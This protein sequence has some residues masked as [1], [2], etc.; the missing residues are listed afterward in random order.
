MKKIIY[1]I[2]S[3]ILLLNIGDIYNFNNSKAIDKK[4]YSPSILVDEYINKVL[5]VYSEYDLIKRGD[6]IVIIMKIIGLSDDRASI[7]IDMDFYEPFANDVFD[8]DSGHS[9]CHSNKESY[10]YFGYTAGIVKG[11]EQ[12]IYPDNYATVRDIFAFIARCVDVSSSDDIYEIIRQN[13]INAG[14]AIE[15]MD[16]YI[17]IKDL[18]T[19]LINLLNAHGEIYYSSTY[20]LK[21]SPE[22]DKE[23]Q[24]TYFERYINEHE[25]EDKNTENIRCK[26]SVTGT[27]LYSLRDYLT[28]HGFNVDWIGTGDIRIYDNDQEFILCLDEYPGQYK[29]YIDK[30]IGMKHLVYEENRIIISDSFD[31]LGEYDIVD[32][33]VYLYP[34][35][36]E[37]LS[38][39]LSDRGTVLSDRGT[40]LVSG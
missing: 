7:Y 40:V 31:Y 28:N 18:K 26:I 30:S 11:Y 5:G 35:A 1:I 13:N 4:D 23:H 14:L 16:S 33:T 3:V 29:M 22:L 36:L 2:V 10:I 17:T 38:S 19:M 24:F 9:V 12:N 34:N 20:Y 39:Y 37:R 25:Y 6:A 32:E 27:E 8:W 21:N 15:N